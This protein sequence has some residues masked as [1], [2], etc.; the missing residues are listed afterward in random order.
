M[1]VFCMSTWLD[2]RKMLMALALMLVPCSIR[3]HHDVIVVHFRSFLLSFSLA[4]THSLFTEKPIDSPVHMHSLATLSN[5]RKKNHE[6]WR[7]NTLWVSF[8]LLLMLDVVVVVFV[9]TLIL[10]CVRAR[11]LPSLSIFGY[12][13]LSSAFYSHLFRLFSGK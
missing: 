2:A 7:K 4:H 8:L 1:H 9:S 10:W 12:K 5:E 11:D 6:E 3:M 13:I